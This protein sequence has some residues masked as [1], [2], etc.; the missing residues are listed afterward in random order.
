MENSWE[1]EICVAENNVVYQLK[2]NF[3]TPGTYE[4]LSEKLLEALNSQK[5]IDVFG[6]IFFKPKNVIYATLLFDDEEDEDDEK[7]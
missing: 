4:E 3:T 6:G 7:N 5:P 2:S 1:I